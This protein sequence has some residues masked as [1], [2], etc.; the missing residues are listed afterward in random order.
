MPKEA[1]L[2]LLIVIM[3]RVQKIRIKKVKDRLLAAIRLKMWI[4]YLVR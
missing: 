1:S 2:R 4:L 3:G